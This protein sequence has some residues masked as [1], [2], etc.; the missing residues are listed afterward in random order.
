MINAYNLV[1]AR[2]YRHLELYVR[3]GYRFNLFDINQDLPKDFGCLT[4]AMIFALENSNKL[5]S[6]R[7]EEIFQENGNGYTP[8][9]FAVISDNVRAIEYIYS[10]DK[11]LSQKNNKNENLLHLATKYKSHKA[12]KFLL[13]IFL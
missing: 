9:S 11:K 13:K 3:L 5:F 10:K 4:D 12:L 8:L 7:N 6:L 1:K 2:E